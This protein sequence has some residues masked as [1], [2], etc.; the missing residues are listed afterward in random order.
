MI[1]I[2][3]SGQGTNV[4]RCPTNTEQRS[5][6]VDPVDTIVS[7]LVSEIRLSMCREL[8]PSAYKVVVRF[9][10]STPRLHPP[11]MDLCFDCSSATISAGVVNA[12]KYL[13]HRSVIGGLGTTAGLRLSRSSIRAA[14]RN[15][16]ASTSKTHFLN[17]LYNVHFYG[18]AENGYRR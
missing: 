1:K 10:A 9:F 2:E 11:I 8:N 14:K 12:P 13:R 4:H 16:S 5:W 15:L 7:L 3:G 6:R 17:N 18:R